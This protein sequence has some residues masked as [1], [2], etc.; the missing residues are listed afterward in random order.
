[1]KKHILTL[2]IGIGVLFGIAYAQDYVIVNQGAQRFGFLTSKVTSIT[3]RDCD[4]VITTNDEN[5]FEIPDVDSITFHAEDGIVHLY[6]NMDNYDE[7]FV[8]RYYGQFAMKVGCVCSSDSK[9]NAIT[10]APPVGVADTV[11]IIS[12]L[13]ENIPTQMVTRNGIYYFS[14]PTDSTF[15]LIYDDG[16]TVAMVGCINYSMEDLENCKYE[17]DA[18]KSTLLHAE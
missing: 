5:L 3:H 15:E 13:E 7:G 2:L 9:F 14:Y 16:E 8:T 4:V 6:D 11:C 18:Y 17:D 10:Y 1:M 12:T